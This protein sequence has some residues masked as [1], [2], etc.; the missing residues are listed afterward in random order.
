MQLFGKSIL[1]CTLVVVAANTAFSQLPKGT[2]AWWSSPVAQDLKLSDEQ[3]K[4][5]RQTIKEYRPRLLE[6]RAAVERAETDLDREF[7]QPAVDTRRASETIDRFASARGDLT[8]TL[9]Q[10]SLKLRTVLKPE[11]WEELQRKRP[12][13]GPG[14]RPDPE[15]Q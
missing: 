13:R 12:A 11:Q 10:M 3:R 6:L 9:S 4:Q 15:P 1:G 7:N 14:K 2:Y 5:I 8:R